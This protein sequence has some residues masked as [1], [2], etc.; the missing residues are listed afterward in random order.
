MATGVAAWSQTAASNATAD[1]NVNMAEGMAPS[2]VNDGIRAAMAS[3][4]KWRDDMSGTLNTT[5]TATAYTVT[6]NQG[7]ASLSA[8][9]G[10]SLALR[11]DKTNG[12]SPTLSVDS[13]AAKPIQMDATLAIATSTVRA[14]SIH[15]ITY[16]N[17]AG[18]FILHNGHSITEAGRIAPHA[19]STAPP[20]WLLCDGTGY[21]RT[22]YADLFAIVSTTYGTSDGSTFKVPDLRGRAVFGK[23]DMGGTAANRIT[24]AGSNFDATVLG[25]TGGAQSK[26]LSQ[27]QLPSAITLS[28]TISSG[29]GSHAN[30]IPINSGATAAGSAAVQGVSSS[31]ATLNSNAATLPAMTGTADLG[32]SGG[33]IPIIPPALVV[34]YVIKY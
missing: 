6:T 27:T 16:D 30:G 20:G 10:K 3:V 28:V 24:V 5:G 29:Q 11:F 32:G 26:T 18:V 19:R 33:Q 14:T 2:Q 7:F 21:S 9:D 25:S 1:A 31:N 13:L 23:D 34:N 12:S 8:L 4:A 15:H 17:A 22:T